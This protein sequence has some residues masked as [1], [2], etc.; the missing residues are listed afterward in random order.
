MFG[1]AFGEPDTYGDAPPG[2]AYLERLLGRDHLIAHAAFE[3]DA[4]AGI[5][6]PAA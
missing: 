2:Q 6:A 3:G 1:E 4:V 5:A